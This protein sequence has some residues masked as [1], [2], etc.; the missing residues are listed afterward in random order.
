MK[1]FHEV[2]GKF[3]FEDYASDG[4]FYRA[5]VKFEGTIVYYYSS[6]GE[7]VE[8]EV[9]DY[10]FELTDIYCQDINGNEQK[11]DSVPEEVYN[12]IDDKVTECLNSGEYFNDWDLS[13]LEDKED[14]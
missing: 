14:V 10:H 3:L 13:I 6:R 11:I 8:A 4:T 5:T 7:A 9:Y 2:D 12:M 1:K